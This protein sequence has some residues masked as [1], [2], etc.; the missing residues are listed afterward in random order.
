MYLHLSGPLTERK[1]SLA[2]TTSHAISNACCH[3]EELSQ[4]VG[5]RERNLFPSE[6]LHKIII[7]NII[8]YFIDP[9]E[10]NVWTAAVDDG[11][12]VGSCCLVQGHLDM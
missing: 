7:I 10:E 9:L 6:Q 12:T 8:T 5:F 4:T 1:L 11:A 3:V 2:L